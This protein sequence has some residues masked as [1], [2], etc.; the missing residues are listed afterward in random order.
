MKNSIIFF[1]L[2]ISFQFM[3]AQSFNKTDKYKVVT[4]IKE[5][6]TEFP[7]YVVNLVRSGGISEKLSTVTIDDTELFEDIFITALENPGLEGVS[8]VIKM[9]VEYLAC[10]AEVNSYY[11]M[12]TDDNQLVLLPELTNIYCE[13]GN[14]NSQYT[15]PSQEYSVKGNILQTETLYNKTSKSNDVSLKNSLTWNDNKFEHSAN[16]TAITSY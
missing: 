14:T 5:N 8:K 2:L 3:N 12:I 10:C 1:I 6:G 7:T 16:N 9:E 13:N 11:Y 15:F 4:E